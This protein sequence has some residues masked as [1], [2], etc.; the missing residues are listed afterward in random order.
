MMEWISENQ[1]LLEWLGSLSL[2][3]FISSLIALLVIIVEIP[4]DYFTRPKRN[5][6]RKHHQNRILWTGLVVLK[7][8]LGLSF[9]LI[10]LLLLLLPGQGLLTI[11]IGLTLMNFPGKFALESKIVRQKPIHRSMNK[12]R[13]WAHKVPLKIPPRLQPNAPSGS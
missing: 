2:V 3:M 11:L 7:N 10:G 6:I 5:P 8:A 12:I 13:R 1:R 4:E 9:V